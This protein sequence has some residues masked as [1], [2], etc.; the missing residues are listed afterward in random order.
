MKK[1][2]TTCKALADF[3][4]A[5]TCVKHMM[6]VIAAGAALSLVSIANADTPDYFV[7]WV[8]PSS[9]NLYVDTGI[10]GK[11]GVKAEVDYIYVQNSSQSFPVMLGAWNNLGSDDRFN[12]VMHQGEN[13][14]WENGSHCLT[15]SSQYIRYGMHCTATVEVPAAGTSMSGVWKDSMNQNYSLNSTG[16]SAINTGMSFYLFASHKRTKTSEGP[17]QFHAGRLYSCKLWTGDTGSWTLV[18]NLRPCVKNGVAGLYD[19][20]TGVIHYP[21]SSVSGCELVAGPVD[22]DVIATWNGGTSPTAAQLATASN[23]TC[24]DASGASVASAV[25]NRQTLV[26][27]PAGVGAMTLPS[28]YSASW[29]AVRIVGDNLHP[30]TQYAKYTNNRNNIVA[31]PG[32]YT[33]LG[34][35]S[36]GD[37]VKVGGATSAVNY[38]GLQIR[39]D[40]WFYVNAAQA[41]TWTMNQDVDD[42]YAFYID[43]V[44]VLGNYRWDPGVSG[45]TCE[46]SEGWHR[47]TSIVGD[48]G[49]GWGMEYSFGSDKVP[50][51][52]TVNGSNYVIS[53]DTTFPKGSGTSVIT[54]N[55]NADWSAFG[56]LSLSGGTVLDLNGHNLVVYDIVADDYLGTAVKNSASANSTLTC[57]TS[58]SRV[59]ADGIITGSGVN[60]MARSNLI[61]NGNFESTT[62]VSSG[63]KSIK[64]GSAS[65]PWKALRMSNTGFIH[66]S[67]GLMHDDIKAKC[68]TYAAFMQTASDAGDQILYQDVTVSEPGLH[69]FSV[70]YAAR[71]SGWNGNTFTLSVGG[72]QLYQGS[73]TIDNY[74]QTFECKVYIPGPGVYRVEVKCIN[75]DSDQMTFFDDFVLEK[76][77]ADDSESDNP[78][79]VHRYS[80]NG[81]W[82]DTGTGG[83]TAMPV[84]GATLDGNNES[85]TIANS[86]SGN[87]ND[88]IHFGPNFLPVNGQATLEFWFTENE[89]AAWTRL[90]HTGASEHNMLMFAHRAYPVN[91]APAMRM[92][93]PDGDHGN[94]SVSMSPITTGTRYYAA[95]V[96]QPDPAKPVDTKATAY[97]YNANTHELL[98][99][100]SVV[101]SNW[102]MKD[103][104]QNDFFIGNSYLWN[105][106]DARIS[107]DEFRVW[108]IAFSESMISASVASGPDT[109]PGMKT[110]V[111]VE[112]SVRGL[113]GTSA[114]EYTITAAS[115]TFTAPASATD[116]AGRTWQPTGYKLERYDANG[117]CW[118]VEKT[119][120]GSSVSCIN[121]ETWAKTRL[122]WNWELTDGVLA[123]DA[124]YY[125]PN[126]LLL[127]FDAI[128]NAGLTAAHSTDATTWANLGSAGGSAT[129]QTKDAS[130]GL[131]EWSDKAYEHTGGTY[132]QTPSISLAHQATVQIGCDVNP[133]AQDVSYPTYFGESSDGFQLY[134]ANKG[135]NLTFKQDQVSADPRPVVRNWDGT[136]ATAYVC[137]SGAGMG[138]DWVA[139]PVTFHSKS[140]AIGTKSYYFGGGSGQSGTRELTGSTY[141]LRVY[142]RVLSADEVVRN[143]ELDN[144]RFRGRWG[145]SKETDLVTVRTS[146]RGADAGCETGS[147]LIRGNGSKTV[148]APETMEINGYTWT[149]RGY[150][151]DTMNTTTRQVE[152]TQVDGVYTYTFTPTAN[153]ANRRLTWRYEMTQ[154]VKSAA[155]YG[156]DDYVQYG[157]IVN[158]DGINNEG[159]TRPHNNSAAEWVNSGSLGG[160]AWFNCSK[161]H[162]WSDLGCV[163]TPNNNGWQG[164]CAWTKDL[165]KIGTE[166]TVQGAVDFDTGGQIASYPTVFGLRNDDGLFGKTS[167]QW[168]LNDGGNKIFTDRPSMNW[169]GKY[170]TGILTPTTCVLTEGTTI[171]T[172]GNGYKTGTA[173]DRGA[174]MLSIGG[175]GT[176]P[177]GTDSRHM[178]G[179]TYAFRLY[180]RAL[181]NEELAHN[182]KVD[183]IRF[184][185]GLPVTN[186]I[187]VV[188]GDFAPTEAAGAYELTGS[189]WTFTADTKY[190]GS[191]PYYPSYKVA[192][193]V[194]GEWVDGPLTEGGSYTYNEG[195]GEVR[196][197]WSWQSPPVWK[198]ADGANFS[199][200][201]NWEPQPASFDENGTFIFNNSSAISATMDDDVTVGTL[202]FCGSA[203]VTLVNPNAATTNT[204]TVTSVENHSSVSPTINCAVQFA[205]TYLVTCDSTSVNFAGGATATYPD[206]TMVNGT[207]HARMLT[208][209]IT[210]TEDWTPVS[211][212][213]NTLFKVPSGSRLYGQN[214]NG[215][216]VNCGGRNVLRVLEGGYAEFSNVY[217]A[218]NRMNVSVW[219]YLKVNGTFVA[220]MGDGSQSSIGN[221]QDGHDKDHPGIV[222][223][224]TFLKNSSHNVHVRIPTL[225]VGSGGIKTQF[226]GYH[227]NL[228]DV[229]KTIYATDDFEIDAPERSGYPN[230]WRLD[231][232]A[233]AT[234]NTQGHTITW[235]ESAGGSGALTKEGEGTLIMRSRYCSMTGAITVNAGTFVIDCTNGVGS[236]AITVAAG[237]TLKMGQNAPTSL[238]NAVT[239]AAGSTLGFTVYGGEIRGALS[240]VTM[241][242]SGTVN[243]EF[244]G[245]VGS[246]GTAYT[247]ISGLSEVELSRFVVPT[248]DGVTFSVADGALKATV[249]KSVTDFY[250]DYNFTSGEPVFDH[251]AACT[252]EPNSELNYRW[253]TVP[254]PGG[255]LSAAHPCWKGTFTDGAT[256]LSGDWSLAMSVKP[257]TIEKGVLL[258]LGGTSKLVAFCSSETAGTMSVAVSKFGTVSATATLTG[259]DDTA[260][261]F[262]S[263][264]A[265]HDSSTHT[266]SFYCDGVLSASTL[267]VGDEDFANGFQFGQMYGGNASGYSDT[268]SRADVAFQNVRFFTRKLS[269]ED[270]GM[271]MDTYPE[272]ASTVCGIDNYFFRHNFSSGKLVVEGDGYVEGSTAMAGT[273][274]A[275]IGQNQAKSVFPAYAGEGSVD[276]GLNRDWTVAMSVK[277]STSVNHGVL[278]SIGGTADPRSK[279]FTVCTSTTE[280][281]LWFLNPQ[282]YGDGENTRNTQAGNNLGMTG[283]GDTAT[284]FH[285]LVLAYSRTQRNS[286][287]WN[288]ANSVVG[289]CRI[290]WDGVYKGEMNTSDG[291]DRSICN[292]I[293]YGAIFGGNPAGSGN[294]NQPSYQTLSDASCGVA[295]QD[296][297][298]YT[299][300]WTS[301]EAALY[302]AA[303][304]LP[305]NIEPRDI[306]WSNTAGDGSLDTAENWSIY[307]PLVRDNVTV[308]VSAGTTLTASNQYYVASMDLVGSGAVS[309]GFSGPGTVVTS[310]LNVPE[311]MTLTLPKVIFGDSGLTGN[312]DIVLAPGDGNTFTMSK[313]NNQFWGG[314]TVANGT[315]KF[316]DMRS[317]GGR[318]DN[319]ANRAFPII[320]VKGGATLDLN[321]TSCGDYGGEINRAVLEA[322][323][324]LKSTGNS[325]TGL[326]S[327]VLEGDATVDTSSGLVVLAYAYDNANT[328]PPF[329][330]LNSYT[331]TKTGN[332]EFYVSSLRIDGTGTFDVQAGIVCMA[333]YDNNGRHF[334]TNTFANGTLRVASG[335]KFQLHERHGHP[336]I[337]SV[338][339]LE[340]DGTIEN[341]AGSNNELIVTGSITGSGTT[342]YL[343]LAGGAIKPA[344]DRLT[345]G[346]FVGPV[347]VDTSDLSFTGNDRIRLFKVGTAEGLPAKGSISLQGGNVPAGWKVVK[348]ADGLGYD[349]RPVGA[350]IL[351]Y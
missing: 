97:V 21:V 76:C 77:G 81:N 233:A 131:G 173:Y 230:D 72:T 70:K 241:P 214:L 219:G 202:S 157:L 222:D 59:Y 317:F 330:N 89:A 218:D 18:R 54:L 64:D 247:L 112:D 58:K 92:T 228:A 162:S 16:L 7:K 185:G 126:G 174:Q 19:S 10:I 253:S 312:G 225:Y 80:F 142:D 85:C 335:A 136:F 319:N 260:G 282:R 43:D 193:K 130:K 55:A 184:R 132:F 153:G 82:N 22:Y 134:T 44:Q 210:F 53:D 75:A 200:P 168:K 118:I 226:G 311:G 348:S 236:G 256:K 221:Y 67:S 111:T 178:K 33:L 163:F 109:L 186:V 208:G 266:I 309:F 13:W 61:V 268:I 196:L 190:D 321:A 313:A 320:R 269:A 108:D 206:P 192:T 180:N 181:T 280:G 25:P 198:G 120:T 238:A 140:D 245:N 213:Q 150:I 274:T 60:S 9:P 101:A 38:Q 324:T 119:G 73:T 143:R 308:N 146:H 103:F 164:A 40:G 216:A 26:V 93:R 127:H 14:R 47:F 290:Y 220:G 20:V 329:I 149:L 147:W 4:C 295:F 343:T 318:R 337:F 8:Q 100:T 79:P 179:T 298:F 133:T 301:A 36:V 326:T 346:T 15:H 2:L 177:G 175:S 169:S 176:N 51:V 95:V 78:V 23:W 88:Y 167:M 257:G 166:F 117:S 243:I 316:G 273:G 124:D 203:A 86:T 6:R 197:T 68:G 246:V 128:R 275:L 258:S 183:E 34:E 287:N 303:Y 32:K 159:P 271:Y 304:P 57:P 63:N 137:G 250:F 188:D 297:R 96:L 65:A 331:L 244:E 205:G 306:T 231:L 113:T 334:P 144:V 288:N 116:S 338:K 209:V 240:N 90:F 66:Y 248:I 194:N 278:V 107:V 129:R 351:V 224:N 84:G 286:G 264:V 125:V 347:A 11:S 284:T 259:L 215:N 94:H 50:F 145:E 340:L 261:A 114:G 37:I 182:R 42:Y 300:V 139:P 161:F 307:P 152:S 327:L 151:L 49:G 212:T 201:T 27:F 249:T 305:E 87:R 165:I 52:L 323:A 195:D 270:V 156:V 242:D 69:T 333:D 45:K 189:S 229:A 342:P 279:G 204:L 138:A 217:G 71:K 199:D 339:D 281:K 105:D 102:A 191:V 235:I 263:I 99:T 172:S 234:F 17:D 276:G 232:S 91:S 171:P 62:G 56:T 160:N 325:G 5:R 35:G 285:T 227:F 30:A 283:L 187:V 122:T 255:L 289:V 31:Q 332:N 106:N 293:K 123:Y 302:A 141:T 254:G 237:A 1:I 211:F 252:D 154:G 277:S 41:G 98:G 170:Y 251:D 341:R 148:T 314:V 158:Y 310:T 265:V 12:L 3:V 291:A 135:A 344:D 39:H 104:V 350:M 322:G 328:T 29:G 294:D 223:A 83:V 292:G 345:V 299:N 272:A 207:E 155:D 296:L 121:S 46:V 267:S 24:T 336:V 262:H 74:W 48:T 28:G 315:V 115:Q 239:L 110:T 349:I